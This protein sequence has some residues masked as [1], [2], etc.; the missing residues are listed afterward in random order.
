LSVNAFSQTL[1]GNA[2]Y[3]FLR[4]PA[5]P[6]ATAAGGINISAK[7][8]EVSL[9]ALNPALLSPDLSS[10]LNATFNAFLGGVHTYSL[11]GAH[12]VEKWNTTFS[13]HIYYVDY[14]S[15]PMSDAVGNTNG[16]F[17]PVDYV[18]QF[19]AAKNYLERW[20]YGVAIKWIQ[21]TYQQYQSSAVAVDVGLVYDDS[22]GKFTASFVAKNMGFQIKSFT[23][24]KEDLPFDL[25]V[26]I[27]KRLSKAP[28]GFSLTA[29][30]LHRLN[31]Q[32]S[33]TLFSNENGFR[34]PSSFNK[35][36]NHFILATHIYI[37]QNLEATVGYN[38]LRRSELSVQNAANG[39]T[40]FSAGLRL[41]FNKIQILYARSSYQKGIS[42]NQIGITAQLNQFGGLGN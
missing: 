34:S 5:S 41:K 2:A 33:D 7:T 15:I 40:G 19:S 28:F 11:T 27:T 37:G 6:L 20:T 22:A 10:Q 30:H 4:L 36:F 42:F 32:Y 1:G 13:G 31:I 16:D 14:G 35:I 9:T 24:E 26:G 23:D 3:Q 38:H 39:L 8:K 21:S 18:L 12:H 25:Q 29:Q 17:R